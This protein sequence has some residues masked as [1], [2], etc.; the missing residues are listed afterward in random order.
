MLTKRVVKFS[1]IFLNLLMVFLLVY[2]LINYKI[3]SNEVGELVK[4]GGLIVM[5]LFVLILEGAPVALGGSVA[6]AAILTLDIFNPVLVLS[7]FLICAV[8]A[9]IGYY[10]IG[11]HYGRKILKYFDKD[12]I[13][14]YEKF[15][16]KYGSLSMILMAI[17]PIPYLP[18]IGGVFGMKYLSLFIVFF[19]RILRHIVVFFIWYWIIFNIL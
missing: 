8:F 4:V 2:S 14:K 7:L 9:G 18:T 15:F 13:E 6:V 19:V 17:T 3:L 16:R 10:W 1:F 5:C 11:A 12:S